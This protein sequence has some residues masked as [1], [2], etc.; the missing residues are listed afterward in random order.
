MKFANLLTLLIKSTFNAIYSCISAFIFYYCYHYSLWCNGRTYQTLS[1]HN[2]FTCQYFNLL[3]TC[4]LDMGRIRLPLQGNTIHFNLCTNVFYLYCVKCSRWRCS[5]RF[6]VLF[7]SPVWSLEH[8]D[9][10]KK[11]VLHKR[12]QF[13]SYNH[14]VLVNVPHLCIHFGKVGKK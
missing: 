7:F 14:F 6:M 5:L 10:N 3:Y 9:S 8:Q 1:L 11:Y 13:K 4:S 12:E 2:I